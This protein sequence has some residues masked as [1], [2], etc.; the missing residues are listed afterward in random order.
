VPSY[1]FCHACSLLVL[2][3]LLDD[4]LMQFLVNFPKNLG[5]KIGKSHARAIP[6]CPSRVKPLS[7]VVTTL[8]EMAILVWGRRAFWS[9]GN[10]NSWGDTMH[11]LSGAFGCRDGP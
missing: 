1:S 8:S 7:K 10:L 11:H 2:I 5:L 4:P 6:T 3:L 9:A